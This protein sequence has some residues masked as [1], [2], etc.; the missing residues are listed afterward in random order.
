ML[1]VLRFQKPLCVSLLG[2]YRRIAAPYIY[3]RD[4]TTILT[5]S[6]KSNQKQKQKHSKMAKKKSS[7]PTEDNLLLPTPPSTLP[8]VD[9]HTHLASTFD[10]YRGR[11]K[12]GKYTDVYAF[13]NAMYEGRRVEA[14]VDVWCEAPVRK[15]WKEFADSA[16]DK[17]AK[18]KWGGMEYWFALGAFV[19]FSFINHTDA[20]FCLGVH[21]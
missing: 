15:L 5:K 18:A 6:A 1:P 7:T 11:Y 12:E 8:I 21:P 3:H 13:L 19:I 20:N 17:E 2:S 9:T 16:M 4:L 14:I 10:Y